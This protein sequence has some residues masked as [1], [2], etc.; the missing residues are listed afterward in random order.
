MK[1][2]LDKAWAQIVWIRDNLVGIE[3]KGDHRHRIPSQLLD[4][5]IEH[6]TGILNLIAANISA[7]AF[8]LVRSEF[9]CFVRGAWLYH[10]ASDAE[11]ETFIAK[12]R[13]D[14]S[15]GAMIEAIEQKPGFDS[16][17]LSMVKDSAMKA[18]H[19]YQPRHPAGLAAPLL[20]LE[21]EYASRL[22]P[23]WLQGIALGSCAV[24]ALAGTRSEVSIGRD[25]GW[26]SLSGD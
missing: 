12:D 9:E 19:G 7:S 26:R 20:A 2:G 5:A 17:F 24:A 18:M 8:A 10:C 14:P 4:L 3:M 22:E 13:I 25:A 1:N 21:R 6:A 16:K 23:A 11:I 15:F